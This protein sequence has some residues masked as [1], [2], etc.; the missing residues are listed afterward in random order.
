M[1]T[2]SIEATSLASARGFYAALSEFGPEILDEQGNY[3]VSVRFQTDRDIIRVLRALELHVETRG[4]V[5]VGE[6]AVLR[7]WR[8]MADA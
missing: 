7:R 2:L 4:S 3:T 1:R 5:A 6:A 8:P